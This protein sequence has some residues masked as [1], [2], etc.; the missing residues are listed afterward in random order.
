MYE[1]V[2][3]TALDV[4]CGPGLV[5]DL[6]SPYLDARGVDIDQAAVSRCRARGLAAVVGRGEA[7]PFEDRSF[8]IV[9][10]SYFLLWV[11]D[12]EVVVREMARVARS[13]VLC[14]AEPDYGGRIS[15]PAEVEVID[16]A[17]MEG[18]RRQGAD[19]EMGRKLSAILSRCG[20]TP[21]IGTFS[22]MWGAGRMREEAE[23]EWEEI[24]RLTSGV[25]DQDTLM[26]VKKAWD[27]AAAE[28]SLVQHNP[29]FYA[30]AR[31]YEA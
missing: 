16:R 5:I 20:L 15:Y 21:M 22:G 27:R 30:L 13:W 2:R 25:L 28:G 12:P 1:G 17:M 26:H 9:Y 31:K 29:V 11:P 6:L 10:C 4:G 24:Q 19:P 14:L 18:L 7:L 8:D 3:P 23:Q